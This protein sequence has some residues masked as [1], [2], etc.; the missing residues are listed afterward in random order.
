M[1]AL[2]V[3]L[4]FLCIILAALVFLALFKEKEQ[5][6]KIIYCSFK[7]YNKKEEYNLETS[8]EIFSDN[9]EVN[10][11]K[12]TEIITSDKDNIINYFNMYLKSIYE[13]YNKNYGGFYN[14]LVL[15][16][17][18]V[19]STTLIDYENMDL[20]KYLK[21]N[22]EVKSYLDSKNKISLDNLISLYKSFGAK[23]K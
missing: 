22:E 1:K 11:V 23:C 5:E 19:L 4:I 9:N 21:D 17:N 18:K 6:E 2:K 15:E 20:D 7:M 10:K 3:I 14:N 8:Y 13:T 12:V 16:K